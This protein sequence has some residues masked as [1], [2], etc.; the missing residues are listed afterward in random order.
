MLVVMPL[1]MMTGFPLQAQ[2]MPSFVVAVD[3][4]SRYIPIPDSLVEERH[5]AE[6]YAGLRRLMINS[7]A[8]YRDA[9]VKAIDKHRRS[10]DIKAA[11]FRM[12]SGHVW[13]RLLHDYYPRLRAARVVLFVSATETPEAHTPDSR[14]E[15]TEAGAT[16]ADTAVATSGA[17]MEQTSILSK[18][19]KTSLQPMLNVKTNLLY[20]IALVVPQYGWAPTPNIS[21]EFM[22][23]SGHITAVA[24]WMGSGWRSDKRLKTYILKDILLEGRYYL[25]GDAA[26]TGHYF[27]AYGNLGEF[28]IQFSAT[29]AWINDKFGKAWGCGIGWGYVRRIGQSP[30]KWEVNAAVGYLHTPY[31]SYHPAEDW[32]VQGNFYYNWHDDPTKFE[33]R[34]STF[35]YFG[36]TH[37]GISISYDLPWFGWKK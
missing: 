10:A 23:R 26:Y 14:S 2:E 22:P 7:D 18:K 16:V 12:E 8:P 31:D 35:N 13:Q 25:Q 30:W 29:K 9:V 24:E 37:L 36:L 4:L 33:K 11:L 5:T 20:D 32:A 21:L 6:D 15:P 3:S 17:I 34:R 1:A 28:D 27:A 19:E